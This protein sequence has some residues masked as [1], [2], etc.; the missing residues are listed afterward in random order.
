[1]DLFKVQAFEYRTY[2]ILDPRRVYSREDVWDI[3]NDPNKSSAGANVPMDPYYVIMKLPG[4]KKE[5][6][7]LMIPFTPKD[8]TVLNGWVAARMDPGHYGEMIGFNFPRAGSR[9]GKAQARPCGAETSTCSR[10]AIHWPTSSRSISPPRR[11]S[12]RCP[13]FVV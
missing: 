3:A 1:E 4:E 10:S 9:C 13:S 7:L 6:F 8:R 2:H 11:N 12:S 5:E